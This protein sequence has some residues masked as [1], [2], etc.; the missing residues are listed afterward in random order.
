MQIEAKTLQG[1]TIHIDDSKLQL[2]VAAYGIIEHE[3]NVLLVNVRS[4]GKWFLPG[5]AIEVNETLVEALR[6]EVK[7]ETGI[8]IDVVEPCVLCKEVFFYY[9][10][11][12][13]AYHNV[14]IYFKAI[15][16]NLSVSEAYAVPDDEAEKP[17]WVS[18]SS[19]GPEDFQYPI[20]ELFD[21]ICKS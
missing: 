14:G 1:D 3:G 19:L 9:E 10:P 18:K 7:E 21:L 20:N 17:T 12:D 11:F 6:R 8:D 16:K 13:E 4:T 2:R 5:G 15:P